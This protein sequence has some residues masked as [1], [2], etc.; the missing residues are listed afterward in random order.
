MAILQTKIIL[1]QAFILLF[2]NSFHSLLFLQIILAQ[3]TCPYTSIE[4]VKST[5]KVSI[6][7]VSQVMIMGVVYALHAWNCVAEI[8]CVQ[9]IAP[10]DIFTICKSS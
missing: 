4:D 2:C 1:H 7:I 6:S 5:E 8:V 10:T 9:Y 3:K